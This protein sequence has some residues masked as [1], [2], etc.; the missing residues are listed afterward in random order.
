MCVNWLDSARSSGQSSDCEHEHPLV[1]IT[2]AVDGALHCVDPTGR[3]L[4]ICEILGHEDVR[5]EGASSGPR[6]TVMARGRP[7]SVRRC[8]NDVIY[9]GL[10]DG[11]VHIV[12]VTRRSVQ[13]PISNI[14]STD[15]QQQ[16]MDTRGTGRSPIGTRDSILITV[17]MVVPSPVPRCM[18]LTAIDWIPHN[19]VK[20]FQTTGVYQKE[21]DDRTSGTLITGDAEGYLRFFYVSILMHVI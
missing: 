11:S 14:L 2:G 9:C 7:D 19:K 3:V 6:L 4:A 15:M 1:L 18:A 10:S 21:V 8:S 5:G 20:Y 13:V 12:L 17:T 16:K